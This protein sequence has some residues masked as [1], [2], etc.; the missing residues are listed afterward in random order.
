MFK[1][2]QRWV[3]PTSDR[4]FIHRDVMRLARLSAVGTGPG[5]LSGTIRDT[6]VVWCGAT[7]MAPIGSRHASD[8]APMPGFIP[9]T[10]AVGRY[11]LLIEL[12]ASSPQPNRLV[13]DTD[14]RA[15]ERRLNRGRAKR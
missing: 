11:D 13:I 1:T 8:N 5:S 6:K 4:F 2:E 7:V 12:E 10:A 15:G 3:A 9:A 14:A